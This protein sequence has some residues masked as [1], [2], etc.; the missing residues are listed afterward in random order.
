MAKPI[1]NETQAEQNLFEPRVE[2]NVKFEFGKELLT[3]L[4]NNTFDGRCEEDVIG[5]IVKVLEILDLVKIAGVDP[6]QLRMKA[7]DLSLS[8]N[9]DERW[10]W[11]Y[12][13]LGRVSE[14]IFQEILSSIMN[15]TAYP[16]DLDEIMIWY[17]YIKNHKK[18][19]KNEQARTR[20]LEE[21]KKKPKNQSRGQ[22]VKDL[23]QI[24]STMVNRNQPLQDKTSQ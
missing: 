23:S 19:V 9:A 24:Q 8:K 12:Y 1:L 5:H 7:F 18:T 22:K 3:E 15:H 10:R 14:E 21:N 20:E 4:Q 13:H 2:C 6:F 16:K 11:D 17:G